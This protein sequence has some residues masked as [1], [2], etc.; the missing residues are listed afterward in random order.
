MRTYLATRLLLCLTSISVLGQTKDGSELAEQITNIVPPPPDAAAITKYGDIPVD[1]YNGLPQIEIPIYTIKLKQV[2]VPI[3]LKYHASG[4]KVNDVASS[5]GLGWALNAGGTIAHTIVGKP[6]APGSGVSLPADPYNFDPNIALTDPPSTDYNY[7][8]NLIENTLDPH[9]DKYTFSLLGQ[10]GQIVW[11]SSQVGHTIPYQK[12]KITTNGDYKIVDEKGVIYT[13]GITESQTS[14]DECL[15]TPPDD[16]TATG[17]ATYHLSKIETPNGE[18][19]NLTYENVNYDY[20]SSEY[21]TEFTP[22][23]LSVGGCDQ[24][25]PGTQCKQKITVTGKRLTNIAVVDG[26]SVSFKYGASRTDLPGTHS[27]DSI[28]IKNVDGIVERNFV[29]DHSYFNNSNT[30]DPEN[31]KRLK[32]LSVT[33]QAPFTTETKVHTFTY[34]ESVSLP[35]RLSNDRD[36]WGYYNGAGNGAELIPDIAYLGLDYTSGTDRSASATH[37]EAGMLT[38]IEYPTGGKTVF[39]Y[40]SY[41]YSETYTSYSWNASQTL[42]DKTVAADQTFALLDAFTYDEDIHKT[43]KIYFTLD[44][45]RSLIEIDAPDQI[46]QI[47]ENTNS[48]VTITNPAPGDYDIT[49]LNRSTTQTA[50]LTVKTDILTSTS[51]TETIVVG[52]PRIRSITDED[53]EGNP[54][55]VRYFHYVAPSSTTE[56]DLTTTSSAH[57]VGVPKYWSIHNV[58]SDNDLSGNNYCKYYSLSSASNAENK[59][60]SYEYVAVSYGDSLGAEG[61]T[62]LEYKDKG[63]IA[64][65]GIAGAQGTDYS[66]MRG[67]LEKKTDYK[68]VNSTTFAKVREEINDYTFHHDTT[69]FWEFDQTGAHVSNNEF[70]QLGLNI[71]LKRGA[72]SSLPAE[73]EYSFYKQPSAWYFHKKKTVKDFSDTANPIEATTEYFYDNPDHVQVSR[74]KSSTGDQGKHQVQH[75][76][77][78]EDYTDNTGFVKDMKDDHMHALPIE[79]T[80]YLE[81]QAGTT[82]LG[83]Q[84]SMLNEYHVSGQIEKQ[85]VLDN[86]AL[87]STSVFKFSSRTNNDVPPIGSPTVFTEHPSLTYENRANLTYNSDNNVVQVEQDG[88]YTAYVWGHDGLRLVA[89]IENA[90][91]SQVNTALSA[92]YTVP[93][94]LS[95]T[96][97]TALRGISNTMVTTYEYDDMLRLTKIKPPN[98]LYQEFSYDRFDRLYQVKDHQGNVLS[99]NSYNHNPSN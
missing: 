37:R 93:N 55:V 95:T 42:Y 86:S 94:G 68:Y 80:R 40:E 99:E 35:P 23:D 22:L 92:P 62:I 76:Q 88:A 74:I 2:S 16:R 20:Y 30:T 81:N 38:E 61:R 26:L 4:I 90:T 3:S 79:S 46:I 51:V 58:F 11:D 72:T 44:D 48:P 78:A 84:S 32:L 27:L 91:E 24:T 71:K 39:D 54:D 41:Q 53:D 60:T 65:G 47:D 96:Q 31:Y 82:I 25:I 45:S 1:Y 29:L 89:K 9:P 73:F 5:V 66:W 87:L 49:I 21:Q 52:T 56:G 6:N 43:L 75:F 8:N 50:T 12:L 19:V 28:R 83:I 17:T 36:H 33:E 69:D 7:A 77:Y 85:H 57:N 67:L 70:T 14:E 63:D 10:A 97:E 59:S 15:V 98:K 18:V 64:N 34:N 13:F